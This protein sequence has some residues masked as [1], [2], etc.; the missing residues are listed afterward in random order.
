MT[1]RAMTARR[2]TSQPDLPSTGKEYGGLTAK[3]Q[4]RRH[5]DK[6]DTS[7]RPTRLDNYFI[8]S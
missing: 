6:P 1:A 7:L 5:C 4:I 3:V 8:I 2:A